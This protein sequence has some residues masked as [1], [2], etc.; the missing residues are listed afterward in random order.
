[1]C[2]CVCRGACVSERDLRARRLS[3]DDLILK[4][5]AAKEVLL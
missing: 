4:I 2:V 1:M 5:P 3:E